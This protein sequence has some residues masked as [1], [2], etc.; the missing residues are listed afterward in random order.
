MNNDLEQFS[1][2][3]LMQMEQALSIGSPDDRPT[4]DEMLKITRIALAAK[5]AKPVCFIGKKC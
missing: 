2:E 4:M 5:Q 1:E 3:R